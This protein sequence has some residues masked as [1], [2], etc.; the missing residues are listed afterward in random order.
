MS[1]RNIAYRIHDDPRGR[2]EEAWLDTLGFLVSRL[3]DAT[4]ARPHTGRY[5]VSLSRFRIRGGWIPGRYH[6]AIRLQNFHDPEDWLI[7]SEVSESLKVRIANGD[8]RA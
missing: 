2:S 1:K 8:A 3:E 7:T 4:A 5:W 6:V